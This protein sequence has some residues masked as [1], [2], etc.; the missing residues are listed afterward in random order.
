VIV[1][2]AFTLI[3]RQTGSWVGIGT[4]GSVD[5]LPPVLTGQ[6]DQAVSDGRRGWFVVVG[7]DEAW[8]LVHVRA[9]R[10][11]DP[12][13]HLQTNG[14]IDAVAM[15]SGVLYIG[16]TFT[17]IGK[18]SHHR[19]AAIDIAT[20]KP[21]PWDARVSAKRAKDDASVSLLELSPDG[22][23]LYFAGD[24]ARV[25]GSVRSGYAALDTA[26]GKV[27]P[28]RP[29]VDGDANALVASQSQ[30]YIA[31]DFVRVDG[32]LRD[33]LAAVTARDGALTDWSPEPNGAINT[34]VRMPDGTVIAGGTFTSIGGKSRRGLAR[35]SAESG[36]ATPWDPNVDG[37]V[38]AV[39]PV[40]DT[41]YVGGKFDA[42]GGATRSNLAAVSASSGRPTPW[43]PRADKSVYVLARGAT[44]GRILAGGAMRTVGA[45]A[46][47]GLAAISA[48]GS[49]V[50]PWS[51]PLGGTIRALAFDPRSGETIFA[52]R[53]RLAGEA[54]QRSLGVV[55]PDF[56][57]E[58]WGGDF[59]S[60]VNAVAF[61]PDGSVFVGGSFTTAQGAARK[62]LAQ[63]DP[64]GTLTKWNA[65]ANALVQSLL[66]DG[67]QLFVGGNF[68]SVGGAIRR[69]LAV[70]DTG[71]GLATGWDAGLDG[72][73]AATTLR[74]DTLYVAGTFET[75]GTRPRNYLASVSAET[76]APSTWDPDPDDVVNG[77]CL[78]PAGESLYAVGQFVNVG[79]S[80][81]DAA[82]FDTEAGFLLGWRPDS[83]VA[84]YSCAANADNSTVYLGADGELDVFH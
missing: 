34:L 62:R 79:N 33:E 52:G 80:A 55:G 70:L 35:V 15:R 54:T 14:E 50:L 42:V 32:R 31:G 7:D 51:P 81:R 47:G 75:V 63:L 59:N 74:G 20:R 69:G 83:H 39:L 22:R 4:N 68:T 76:A 27:T 84:G 16:G 44:S 12:S 30:V 45:I 64:A 40:G 38:W 49:S 28:W 48:D 21:L 73:I 57:T 17:K 78:D 82:L 23:T 65:G 18:E 8:A 72:N 37:A 1:G 26:T 19:V 53:Y 56:A 43:D 46:R 58:P 6:V 10:T 11:I 36:G 2:G 5:S 71:N 29:T 61:A 3:G 9:D 60:S 25:R 24:F 66:V 77:L 41:V 13:W 67:D